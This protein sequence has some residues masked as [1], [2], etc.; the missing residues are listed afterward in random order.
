MLSGKVLVDELTSMVQ[1]KVDPAIINAAQIEL[2]GKKFNDSDVKDMVVLKLR[3]DPFA[4]VPEENI[5]L[6]RT[7]NAV[8]QNDL[9]IHSNINQFVT[10]ALDEYDDFASLS[11]NEQ[12]KVMNQYE[13]D[14]Q[15]IYF[16]RYSP[17]KFYYGIPDY[18]SCIQYCAVE[19]EI[20]NLHVNNIRNNF[21][22]S[23]IINFNGGVP[24]VEE[25]YNVEQG[26]INKFSGTTLS[27]ELNRLANGG[28]YRDPSAMVGEALAARQWA[29][30]RT[31]TLT[32]SDTVGVLNQ[33]AGNTDKSA[34]KDFT[35]VCNQ[36]ASSTGLAAAAAL[37]LISS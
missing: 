16:K 20:S 37:R 22:P 28:T 8:R 15:I 1:A 10:R 5:S 7:F 24:A 34:W 23:T 32:V 27:D 29:A 13:D 4:G 26:I 6:Q 21:M 35:G 30:Q 33:I 12:M 18:Y 17:G 25:Q 14:V 9:V 11:Y 19:E 36:L 2:A 31:V 3:L